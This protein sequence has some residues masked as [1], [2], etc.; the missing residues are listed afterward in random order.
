MI[1]SLRGKLN[2]LPMSVGMILHWLIV[3]ALINTALNA[4]FFLSN[5]VSASR[6]FGGLLFSYLFTVLLYAFL[7]SVCKKEKIAASILAF[8]YFLLGYINQIK[9]VISGMNP[10]FISDLLFVT[11][12]ESISVMVTKSNLGGTVIEYLPETLLFLAILLIPVIF[13]FITDYS[14]ACSRARLITLASTFLTLLLIFIPIKSLHSVAYSLFFGEKA[15]HDPIVYYNEKGF[16]SG[17]IGQ[18]WNSHPLKSNTQNEADEILNSLPDQIHG[19]WGKPNIIVIFSESFFDV[20]KLQDVEYSQSPTKN[21]T[22]L[23]EKG[24]SFSILMGFIASLSS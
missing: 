14:I 23:K 18:Y 3:P 11:D 24:I 20:S 19:D 10:V 4:F 1:Q 2:A 16:I 21:F 6:H 15:G 17:I 13:A 9:M 5:N 7:M 8:L 22:A 12:T